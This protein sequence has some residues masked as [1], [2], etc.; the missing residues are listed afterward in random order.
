[1]RCHQ[2]GITHGFVVE[3]DNEEDR[4]Y[5]LDKDPAHLSFKESVGALLDR[6]QVID[7][8]PGKY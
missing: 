2:G 1:L 8:E 3:F 4:E 6:A 5:Y 7:F